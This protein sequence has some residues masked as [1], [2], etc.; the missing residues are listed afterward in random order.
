LES[1]L[2]GVCRAVRCVGARRERGRP[3]ARPVPQVQVV[4]RGSPERGADP[5]PV[6]SD[7]RPGR[8]RFEWQQT[9]LGVL[10]EALGGVPVSESGYRTLEWL[11]EWDAETVANVAELIRAARGAQ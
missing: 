9:R 8:G 10:L 2:R 6:G 3:R 1:R 11:A 7:W 4:N 5:L